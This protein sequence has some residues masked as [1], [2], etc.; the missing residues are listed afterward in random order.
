MNY[1]GFKDIYVFDAL[2]TLFINEELVFKV[3]V[4]WWLKILYCIAFRDYRCVFCNKIN[5]SD[6]YAF[7]DNN[8]KDDYSDICCF[9]YGKLKL[10]AVRRSVIPQ[11]YH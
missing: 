11:F 7:K 1:K 8:K 2:N 6:H 10:L 5:F 4:T 3:R 9:C